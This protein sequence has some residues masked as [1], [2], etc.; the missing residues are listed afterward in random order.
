MLAWEE[1]E[2]AGYKAVWERFYEQ[3]HFAPSIRP[4]QWPSIREPVPSLTYDISA[5]YADV[6]EGEMYWQCTTYQR[7]TREL[8]ATMM[9]AFQRCVEAGEWLNALDWQHTCYRFFP[10]QCTDTDTMLIE[11]LPDGDYSIFLSSDMRLG[12]FGHPWEQTICVFGHELLQSLEDRQPR[13]F[14][15]LIRVNGVAV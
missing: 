6:R 2:E 11:V 9:A 3:F 13:L 5:I 7:L 4:E 15:A 1:L 14:S 12:V 10:H 8:N